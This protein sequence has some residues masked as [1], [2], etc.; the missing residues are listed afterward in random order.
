MIAE[1]YLKAFYLLRGKTIM[2]IRYS[3]IMAPSSYSIVSPADI[4]I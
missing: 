3:T 1:F 4:T 2:V